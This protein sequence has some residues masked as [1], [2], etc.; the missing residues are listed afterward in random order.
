MVRAYVDTPVK[1]ITSNITESFIYPTD[2]QLDC[3][4]NVKIH[5]RGAS[6]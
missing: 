4:Q 6:T 5:M 2:A 3:S 1:V